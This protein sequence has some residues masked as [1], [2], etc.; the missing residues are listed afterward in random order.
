METKEKLKETLTTTECAR[1]HLQC[2]KAPTPQDPLH[3]LKAIKSLGTSLASWAHN[4]LEVN[5]T[6]DQIAQASYTHT[7]AYE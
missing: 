2:S 7:K 5:R 4:L 6:R 3:N 1:T